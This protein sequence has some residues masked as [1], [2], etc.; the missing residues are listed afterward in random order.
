MSDLHH[1]NR[2]T[3]LSLLVMVVGMAGLAYAS[4]P[5]YSLFC[6]V[7]GFG[8]TTQEAKVIPQQPLDRKITVRFN[9]DVAPGLNWSFKP[10][11]LEVDVRIGEQQLVFYEVENHENTLTFGTAIYNVTPH[12]AGVYFN[13][14]KC[15]C[16][17]RQPVEA[18]QRVD[19]PVSFF[20]DPA[21]V[22]DPDMR[23]VKTITLSYTFFPLPEKP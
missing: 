12:K 11:Q 15:F 21:F 5:L 20:I 4:V 13:K 6:K 1:K 8:G 23:D 18:G 22:D 2:R 9:A 16:Y 14:I 10:Q 19:M 3:A 17:D 7:T